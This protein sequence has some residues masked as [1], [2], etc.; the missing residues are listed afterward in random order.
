M[1]TNQ[2]HILTLSEVGAPTPPQEPVTVLLMFSQSTK[3]LFVCD[4][5]APTPGPD[6]PSSQTWGSLSRV[7]RGATVTVAVQTG[8]LPLQGQAN[9]AAPSHRELSLSVLERTSWYVRNKRSTAGSWGHNAQ[10]SVSLG[11]TVTHRKN[12]Q[13]SLWALS[14]FNVVPGSRRQEAGS[15]RQE[16][17]SL[18]AFKRF[19]TCNASK[20]GCWVKQDFVMWNTLHLNACEKLCI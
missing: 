9:L 2:G 10:S 12:R 17:G 18:Y 13:G 19:T 6:V 3:L 16:T 20:R 4:R 15:R 7:C 14:K 1:F 11:S 5:S 8:Q